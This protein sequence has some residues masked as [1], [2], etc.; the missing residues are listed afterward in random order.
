MTTLFKQPLQNKLFIPF[1]TAGDPDPDT[2]VEIA[3]ALQNAG[4][5][6]IE[7]G[8]PYSDPVADGPVIQKASSRAL[9]NGMNIIQA[10]EL[11]PKMR[12]KGLNIPIIL[13]TYYNPVL[14]LE[15]ESFFALL[16]KNTIDG[17]LI[18]DIPFEESEELRKQ[19]KEHSIAFI[20]LVAPT[21]SS[22]IKMIAEH[23]EGFI[24]CVSS[25][26]VTGV[27]NTFDRSITTFLDEVKKYS[28]VPVV[29]GFGVSTRE[30]V[31]E[32]C[33]ICDGVVVGSA[34]VR[35][36]ERLQPNLANEHLRKEAIND[37]TTYAQTFGA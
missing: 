27:R 25:L 30:Q 32:F 12:K 33:K 2:T 13:F 20:S 8:I 17:L 5:S 31:E 10:M 14:Q 19:C 34:L 21:S 16:R 1:I 6:A 35:E 3:L 15:K 4:A 36:I 18:P 28:K 11:V 7:L 9:A 23:A 29:V 26:G 37:F 24:Y 22:R